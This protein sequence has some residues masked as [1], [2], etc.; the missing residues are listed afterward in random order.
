MSQKA[1][2]EIVESNFEKFADKA[3]WDVQELA[4]HLHDEYGTEDEDDEDLTSGMFEDDE[5]AT[6]DDEDDEYTGKGH[7]KA[8]GELCGISDDI[9]DCHVHSKDDEDEGTEDEDDEGWNQPAFDNPNSKEWYDFPNEI[10]SESE[11]KNHEGFE[12][13][14]IGVTKLQHKQG[15]HGVCVECELA[16]A[17]KADTC[18]KCE[19]ESQ[20]KALSASDKAKIADKVENTDMSYDEAK[21]DFLN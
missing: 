5:D 8:N 12:A 7:K 3:G 16:Y 15:K 19:A 14:N 1:S 18:N 9:E 21:A 6:E 13:L 10:M 2:A 20:K 4:D 17:G 11:I